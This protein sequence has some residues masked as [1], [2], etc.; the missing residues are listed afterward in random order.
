MTAAS[1]LN[2]SRIR[3]LRR[4]SFRGRVVVKAPRHI[5]RDHPFLSTFPA[6][7]LV[8]SR[9]LTLQPSY[10]CRV[11][12]RR[13]REL[14]HSVNQPIFMPTS[15]YSH[16]RRP[17]TDADDRELVNF[18][19]IHHPSKEG[20]MGNAVYKLLTEQVRISSGVDLRITSSS[21]L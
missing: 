21:N 3:T 9:I 6:N 4:T 1:N 7:L 16:R 2:E 12:H 14:D 5:P 19:A 13:L 11:G 8:G 15:P 20:R 10:S 18:L 17:F